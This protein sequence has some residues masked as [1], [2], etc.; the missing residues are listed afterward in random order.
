MRLPPR[1]RRREES[2][3]DGS[4]GRAAARDVRRPGRVGAR[5]RAGAVRLVGLRRPGRRPRARLAR[6]PGGRRRRGGVG[7]ADARRRR[8][9]RGV[10]RLPAPRLAARAAR[11][12]PGQRRAGVLGC[13]RAALPVPLLDLLAGRP[14]AQ[15][16]AHRR[17][18]DRPGR[19]LAAPGRGRGVGGLRVREPHAGDRGALRRRGRQGGRQPRQLRD[20][21]PGHR[22]C[23]DLRRGVQLEGHRRELQ[24]VLP[25]RPGAPR[26]G[27][28]GAGVRRWRHGTWSGTTASR[29][30]RARGRSR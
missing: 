3:R 8:P 25:L 13:R 30:A 29:T 19:L 4:A 22:A 2:G 28:A 10:Q 7:R 16:A 21:R 20:G 11:P 5:A 26:A 23:A 27:A 9:P 17:G 12:E 18:R 1:G 24:R 15:G 14:A 6:A